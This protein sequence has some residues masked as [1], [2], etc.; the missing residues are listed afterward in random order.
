MLPSLNICRSEEESKIAKDC[1][2]LIGNDKGLAEY[3][4]DN[5]LKNFNK[6][7]C[8][9]L[10]PSMLVEYEVMTDK[11]KIQYDIEF[12]DWKVRARVKE[13]REARDSSEAENISH[14]HFLTGCL[15]H[16]TGEKH[17]KV[18]D[19]ILAIKGVSRESEN[20]AKQFGGRI[21]GW[22]E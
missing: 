4:A 5:M 11:E 22:D 10:K 21:V 7:V 19:K 18:E 2:S 6:V 13:Y 17:K 15:K 3:V 12:P 9:E 16:L 1:I 14:I 20:I 8:R